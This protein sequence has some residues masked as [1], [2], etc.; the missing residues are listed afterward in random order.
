[1]QTCSSLQQILL[2][3]YKRKLIF[4][5]LVI[6]RRNSNTFVP[7]RLL[8]HG[9]T[10]RQPL[11]TKLS[12]LPDLPFDNLALLCNCFIFTHSD[13]SCCTGY[14]QHRPTVEFTVSVCVPWYRA[15]VS[16]WYRVLGSYCCVM[17]YKLYVTWEFVVGPQVWLFDVF[18]EVQRINT[19]YIYI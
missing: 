7:S 10:T 9:L 8:R 11:S 4:E 3:L 1:M 18:I 16:G 14:V 15:S 6:L 2:F 17:C 19:I 5:I 12:S 13:S